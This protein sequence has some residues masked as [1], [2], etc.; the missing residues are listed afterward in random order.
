MFEDIDNSTSQKKFTYLIIFV[1]CMFISIHLKITINIIFAI[2]IASFIIIYLNFRN[3]QEINTKK[4]LHNTK[5]DKIRPKLKNIHIIRNYSEI[6][7]LLF[8][9][10]DF[11]AYNPPAYDE[12]I[13]N[14]IIFL[15]T[16]EESEELPELSGKNYKIAEKNKKNAVNNLHSIIFNLPTNKLLTKKLD[17]NVRDLN[18]ILSDMLDKLNYLNSEYIAMK[19]YNNRSIIINNGPE[20]VNLNQSYFELY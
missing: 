4:E 5:F 1:M 14:I 2:G 17:D 12:M 18:K 6:L 15:E 9:I 20:E 3:Q 7:D 10:Q 19:G 8:G 16:Y 13:G 11:Y